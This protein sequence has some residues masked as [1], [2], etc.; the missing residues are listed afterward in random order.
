[1]QPFA[2]AKPTDHA[3]AAAMLADKRFTLPVLKA[4]GMDVVDH[5]KEGLF[6]PDVLIDVKRAGRTAGAAPVRREAGGSGGA[7]EG[8][9]IDAA[10]TLAELI[11]SPIAT[12]L[13]PVLGQSVSNAATPQVRNVATAAGNLLQRPRCWY[14]RNEQFNC[15]KKGGSQCFA[16]E[17]E[18][19]YHAIFGPGPCHIVHPSNLAP[20]LAV[21]GGV[22]HLAGGARKSLPIDALFHMPD[23]GILS[24]HNLEPGEV[25]THITAEARP[26]SGFWTIKA[27]ASF[28]WPMAFAAAALRVE[29]QRIRWASVCAGAVAPVP[30]MLPKVAEALVG[31]TVDDEAGIAKAAALAVE[32]ARPMRDNAYKLKL[33]P[34]AVKRAVLRAAG[35][36]IAK[37]MGVW[38]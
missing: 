3:H 28:D 33:L 10:C 11:E 29:N 20:A 9:R 34:V 37:E 22:V 23:K 12:E 5:L 35:R 36:D 15:L 4:G 27:K 8:L 18:N 30:W 24:E 25:V 14:Y 26:M 6:R 2:I 21:C 1:M 32:G 7:G 13:A 38:A 17:G 19:A 31:L 16:V